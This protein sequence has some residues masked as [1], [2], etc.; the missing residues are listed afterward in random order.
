MKA[1]IFVLL[2]LLL[3]LIGCYAGS[4]KPLLDRPEFK[5]ENEPIRTLR[6]LLIMDNSYRRD[7]IEKFVSKC[8]YLVERQ[9]GIRLEILDW[10]QIQWENELDD[11][12]KMEIRIAAET[13][14]K[15]DKFD[16]ALT[17]VHFVQS[18]EGGKL[19]LGAT[20]TFFWR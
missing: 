3:C 12:H 5:T 19:P 9:V 8:S 14:N 7:E 16:I 13:W 10:H 2:S 18:V 6:I 20:D 1:K 4:V 15:R 17:M 11:I